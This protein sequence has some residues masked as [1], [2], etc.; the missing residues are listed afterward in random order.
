MFQDNNKN[1]NMKHGAIIILKIFKIKE[2]KFRRK[3]TMKI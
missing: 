1:M 3:T 2:V